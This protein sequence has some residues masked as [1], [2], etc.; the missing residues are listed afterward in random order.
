[1]KVFV[2]KSPVPICCA[3]GTP[4][5]KEMSWFLLSKE[6]PRNEAEDFLS[7]DVI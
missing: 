3:I 2:H 5:L 7:K 6:V 4:P 1:M